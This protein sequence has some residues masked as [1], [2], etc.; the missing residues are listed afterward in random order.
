MG[1]WAKA[2]SAASAGRQG[3]E[4]LSPFIQVT[5]PESFPVGDHTGSVQGDFRGLA[6][7]LKVLE[8]GTGQLRHRPGIAVLQAVP[9]QRIYSFAGI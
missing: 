2:L 1:V 7:Y 9:L 4:Y 6:H 3:R 5:A 8:S